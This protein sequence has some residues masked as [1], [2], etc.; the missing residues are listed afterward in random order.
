M[1]TITIIAF[2]CF[3]FFATAQVGVGNTDPKSTLDISASSTTSPTN[4]DGI[5]I[6]RIDNFPTTNPTAD[7]DGMMVFVTGNGTPSKGFYYWDNGSGTW[8]SILGTSN[9]LDEAYDEGGAGL[10]RI[11]TADNGPVEIQGGD[12]LRVD[13]QNFN[14]LFY[15]RG[16][17]DRIGFNT[18]NPSSMIDIQSTGNGSVTNPVMELNTLSEDGIQINLTGDNSNIG[19]N[20]DG[21]YVVDNSSSSGVSTR[22][23]AFS[24]R[25]NGISTQTNHD[26]RAYEAQITNTSNYIGNVYGFYS[27]N[28][29]T[30]N[31]QQFGVLN[32]ISN[33]GNGSH[34]GVYSNLTG[35]GSGDKYGIYSN[36]SSSAGGTHYGVYS[37]TPSISG[38]AGY[39]IGRTSF[40]AGFSNRYIM[41]ATD[42]T[43]GQVMTTDGAGNVTFQDISAEDS[44]WY[45][46]GGSSSPTSIND[47]IF[48]Q[49]NVAIGNTSSSGQTLYVETNPAVNSTSISNVLT[50]VSSGLVRGIENSATLNG[51]T[52]AYLISN[53][54]GGNST[55]SSIQAIRNSFSGSGSGIK[56]GMY[57]FFTFGFSGTARGVVNYF[58]N[59]GIDGAT[60]ITNTFDT[61]NSTSTNIGVYNQAFSA[62]N[63]SYLYGN[64][65]LFSGAS[66]S[67]EAYGTH[68][69]VSTTGTDYGIYSRVDNNSTDYA[70]LFSGRVS[71]GNDPVLNRYFLPGSD[72]T[73]GQ[74]MTT[75]GAGNVTF[76]DIVGDGDTQNT[77]NESYNEG[78]PG[79]GRG[80]NAV[81]GAVEINGEDGFQV[82][83]T[84][85][86]G[87]AISLSGAGTR[88]LFNPRKAAFRAGRVTGNE[89]NNANIG[90]YSFAVG[91]NN[92]ASDNS[93]TAFG[94]SNTVSGIASLASGT[95]NTVSGSDN[96]A[97]GA[98]NTVSGLRSGA[99]GSF[100][101]VNGSD[102]FA[103]GSGNT[104]PS[105]GETT[106]GLWATTYSGSPSSFNITDRIFS[107]GIG[108]G[109]TNRAN[110]LTI[111][112]SGR[113][114]I[115][116]AYNMPLSD[117]TAGQVMTTDGVGNVTFQDATVN[118][119]N[120]QVDTFGLVGN[121]LG[122][123]LE[124][125]GV[126]VQTV[127]L[128]NLSFNV[129]NFS[130]AVSTLSGLYI[131]GGTGYE[132]IAFS[133]VDIDTQGEYLTANSRFRATNDGY[134]RIN[135]TYTT[136]S[137]YTTGN[138]GIAVY[139]N[140]TLI[141]ENTFTHVYDVPDGILHR[142]INC[143]VQ[144]DAL[145]YVEIYMYSTLSGVIVD[146][147]PSKTYFE[148]E[149]I[150]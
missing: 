106:L 1:K 107:I 73:A 145:E 68:N 4:Q 7:Q 33:S 48:T 22:T 85:G 87:D 78:G 140:G 11:I 62:N 141:K 24:A 42:G 89:W 118:T 90:N 136:S 72:G 58:N 103:F 30:N 9:T 38:Y 23:K 27:Q 102:A 121:T 26:V 21:V 3:S 117:G 146:Q 34:Y 43:N 44:D 130:L 20:L 139:K 19:G 53:S 96:V 5:L 10:G 15:V 51:T 39:F 123:S 55:G 77:L 125:D 92:I 14:N 105:T 6:P 93:S 131:H 94:R 124:D 80:I 25:M 143:I 59:T 46:Q 40:G 111:Y 31:G 115:N 37:N 135:A 114:N 150:R 50:P 144:L 91:E 132:K 108:S 149:R 12:G 54:I 36:I 56:T 61:T 113:M 142:T 79:A 74:V 57:N 147:N 122:I 95:T 88:M 97:F 109:P 98:N 16:D 134:Y 64:R 110:A 126:P 49:G 17:N 76:Q 32:S 66:V 41:P 128:G 45:I 119:D 100:N 137:N 86:A 13:S 148:V 104:A 70:A 52:N 60:G 116:D 83:G 29:S 67:N 120:Q 71:I 101:T 133:T 69:V 28:L 35:N 99:M 75:D 84:F 127:N 47:N 112:K 82:V 129:N 138:Y 8:V 18:I 65:T 81:D 2:L 63:S